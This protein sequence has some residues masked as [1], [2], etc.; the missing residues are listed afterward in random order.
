MFQL[1]SMAYGN[2]SIF[3]FFFELHFYKQFMFV[4]W[5]RASMF[6][7]GSLEELWQETVYVNISYNGII[8]QTKL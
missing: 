3:V 4:C 6:V 1:H 7:I 8:W 5:F 2:V